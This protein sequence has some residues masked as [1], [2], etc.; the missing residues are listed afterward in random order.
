MELAVYR[1]TLRELLETK[2]FQQQLDRPLIIRSHCRFCGR[3]L[4]IERA[5]Q[6]PNFAMKYGQ[7]F[8]HRVCVERE[9]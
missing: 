3:S 9:E 7:W 2:Q 5:D 1:K 6:L 8:A 4:D